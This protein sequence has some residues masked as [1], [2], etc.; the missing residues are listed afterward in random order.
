VIPEHAPN[1]AQALPDHAFFSTHRKNCHD[2]HT[3][4]RKPVARA[5]RPDI[6]ELWHSGDAI[7]CTFFN[8]L[9]DDI[10]KSR[11]LQLCL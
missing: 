2:S 1:I 3:N 10:K 8:K 11:S 9:T 5:Q 7:A 6:A 4:E